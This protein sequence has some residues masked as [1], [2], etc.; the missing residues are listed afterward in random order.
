MGWKPTILFVNGQAGLLQGQE[1][2]L[3]EN[4]YR[5]LTANY[6][7][8]VPIFVKHSIDLVLLDH[9]R[10]EINRGIAACMRNSKPDVPIA[11]LSGEYL[12]SGPPQAS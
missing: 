12:A 4:G 2:L 10:S 9:H 8:A 3:E 7:Q 11:V 6:Q 5:V 1:K